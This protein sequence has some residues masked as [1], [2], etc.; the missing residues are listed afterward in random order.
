MKH[1]EDKRTYTAQKAAVSVNK[2]AKQHAGK[3]WELYADLIKYWD[4]IMGKELAQC[5]YP[6]D[7]SFPYQPYEKHRKNGTLTIKLPK[8]LAMEFSFRLENIKQ[9]V[10]K[11]IGY[12][13]FANIKLENCSEYVPAPK[14][15]Y[16]L[17][18]EDVNDVKQL[19]SEINDPELR[20][21][22]EKLGFSLKG[23]PL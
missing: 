13:A 19:S 10:N 20:S 14:K 5:T 11:Y 8:G 12:N 18:D 1:S 7:I 2:I 3:D 9:R 15:E 17:S 22:V 16:K 4:A 6:V 23:T 21:A